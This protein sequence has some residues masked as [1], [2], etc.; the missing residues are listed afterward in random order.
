MNNPDFTKIIKELEDFPELEA[1]S[2]IVNN[3]MTV[4]TKPAQNRFIKIF[5]FLFTSR[6]V[7]FRPAT[8]AIPICIAVFLLYLTPFTEVSDSRLPPRASE[9]DIITQVMQD[10]E[11]SFLMGRGL[12]AAGLTA[13]ALP[14]LRK[15]S[16]TAPDNPNYAFWTGLCFS[17][18]NMPHEE[19]SSYQQAIESSPDNPALLLNLG[20]SFLEERK[21]DDA[22]VYYNQVLTLDETEQVALYNTALIYHLQH[23]KK[24]EETAWKAYLDQY[25]YGLKAFRAVQHLHNLDDFT[26]RTYYIGTLRIILNQTELLNITPQH[27]YTYNTDKLTRY[28]QQNPSLQ[29]D[30]VT[31]HIQGGP[32]AKQKAI[33]LKEYLVNQLEPSVKN[34]IRLSWFGQGETLQTPTGNKQLSE[35]VLIFVTNKNQFSKETAI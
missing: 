31:Y 14:L 27:T 19:R 9:N 25:R 15:A 3:V 13:E 24:D 4:V 16:M 26:Y 7:S 2:N 30:I 35:S 5:H 22:L 29:L 8:L 18:N 23:K 12:M 11:A 32:T 21:Y 17:A 1:P 6:Q 28:L 33:Q 10:T 34:R 20:H